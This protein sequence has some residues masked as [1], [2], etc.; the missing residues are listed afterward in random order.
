M[1]SVEGLEVRY[2]DFIAVH[3]TTISVGEGQVCALI[4]ANGSGKS[5]LLNCIAG[6]M[7]PYAGTVTFDGTDIT[8]RAAKEVVGEGL[9]LVPQGGRCFPRMS[10]MDNLMCGSY[11]KRA[12]TEAKS[13]LE[14]VFDLF[15]VMYEK[16]RELAGSLSGGQMQML[17]IGRAL[18]SRPRCIMFD[19]ISLGLAPVAIQGLYECIARISEEEGL[20]ILVVDQDSERALQMA[21]VGY[22]MLTGTIS[23]SGSAQDLAGDAFRSAYFG[24]D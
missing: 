16:R 13:S 3:D 2:G 8:G 14:R 12:R 24:I 18:M 11:P 1:L 6:L 7:A 19:E 10:V 9:S 17:A 21:D 22:V 15:P 23:L 5:S 4:G 20:T